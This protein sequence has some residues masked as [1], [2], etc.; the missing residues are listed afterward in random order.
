[1]VNSVAYFKGRN[2][3]KAGAVKKILRDNPTRFYKL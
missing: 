2:D 1:M 3:L